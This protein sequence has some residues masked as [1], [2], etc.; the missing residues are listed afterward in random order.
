MESNQGGDAARAQSRSNPLPDRKIRPPQAVV[1]AYWTSRGAAGT[2]KVITVPPEA[3]QSAAIAPPCDS[4]R[5]FAVPCQVRC[6]GL[7]VFN[8]RQVGAGSPPDAGPNPQS[9]RESTMSQVPSTALRPSAIATARMRSRISLARRRTTR[10]SARRSVRNRF[11]TWRASKH[12]QSGS[13]LESVETRESSP[14]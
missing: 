14:I 10:I 6:A 9:P 11:G 13:G 8:A 12:Q 2:S 5:R 1:V 4:S 3:G 7:L